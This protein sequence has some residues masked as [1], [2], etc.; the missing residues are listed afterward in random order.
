MEFANDLMAAL[1]DRLQPGGERGETAGFAD[2]LGPARDWH[3]LHARLSAAY[4]VRQELARSDSRGV[5][6]GGGFSDWPPAA[7]DGV[8]KTP[9]VN[10][11]DSTDGKAPQ[12]ITTDTAAQV[13]VGARGQ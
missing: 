4:A 8:K 1:R 9:G 6:L 10:L 12:R 13:H 2:L 5:M 11:N 3:G 7:C